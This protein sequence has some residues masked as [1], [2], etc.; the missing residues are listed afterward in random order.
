MTEDEERLM[1]IRGERRG[2]VSA[3]QMQQLLASATPKTKDEKARIS[4][5]IQRS[6]LLRSLDPSIHEHLVAVM[7][8]R[9]AK[10]GEVIVEAG[11]GPSPA[12]EFYI[13]EQGLVEMSSGPAGSGGGNQQE[14]SNN[15]G[16]VVKRLV[17]GDSFG[18]LALL[19]NAPQSATFAVPEHV[20]AESCRLWVL[21]RDA[22][23]MTIFKATEARRQRYKGFLRGVNCLKVGRCLC[24]FIH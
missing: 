8:P 11:A 6:A 1:V 12:D 24:L 3:G 4:E 23:R 15:P 20:E 18:E 7:V 2:G 9:E 22:F 13:I 14:D 10:P 17:P 5:S 19:H 21:S 16:R